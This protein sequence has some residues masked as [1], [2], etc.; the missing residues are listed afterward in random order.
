M[1]LLKR[2]MSAITTGF[3]AAWGEYGKRRAESRKTPMGADVTPEQFREA[4]AEFGIDSPA[5]LAEVVGLST[6]PPTQAETI[7]RHPDKLTTERQRALVQK[8]N[9]ICERLDGQWRE[10]RALAEQTGDDE[11]KADATSALDALGRASDALAILA[12]DRYRSDAML[13]ARAEY[14]ARALIES[15]NALNDADRRF[16]LRSIDGMLSSYPGDEA[17]S[18]HRSLRAT[19][20]GHIVTLRRLAELVASNDI[21]K[22]DGGY[23]AAIYEREILNEYV[24]GEG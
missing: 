17:Q 8:A 19:H 7:W 2:D 23:G 4:L 1:T 16:V 14:Q 12:S 3:K 20:F 6:N 11:Y 22:Q 10:M 5:K 18:I 13:A 9:E 24:G 21:L 15:F